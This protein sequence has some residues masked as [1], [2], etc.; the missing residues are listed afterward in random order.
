MSNGVTMSDGGKGSAPR[1]TQDQ[2]AYSN[3]YDVIFNRQKRKESDEVLDKTYKP[4]VQFIG[5]PM[6]FDYYTKEPQEEL[7]NNT[8]ASVFATDHYVWGNDRVRTSVVLKKFD[9]GSFETMN[10]LYKPLKDKQSESSS[11][12]RNDNGS[13]D[14]PRSG[15][16]GH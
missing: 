9:D 4:V 11:G 5:N 15:N 12:H 8:V 3:N 13:Q 14:D 16:E 2:E 6:F 7:T 1:K 10:T